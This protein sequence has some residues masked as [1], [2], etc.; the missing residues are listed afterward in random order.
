MM[1]IKPLYQPCKRPL[2]FQDYTFLSP[3]SL[4]TREFFESTITSSPDSTF[5]YN[6]CDNHF[7]FLDLLESPLHSAPPQSKFEDARNALRPWPSHES[8]CWPPSLSVCELWLV[9]LLQCIHLGNPC[10]QP[11]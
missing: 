11:K 8:L 7:S 4:L 10:L 2:F 1:T 6:H 9:H 3:Q 5:L